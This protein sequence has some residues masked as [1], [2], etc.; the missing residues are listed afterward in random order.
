MDGWVASSGSYSAHSILL[1]FSRSF[2]CLVCGRSTLDGLKNAFVS[3]CSCRCQMDE[4]TSVSVRSSFA[5]RLRAFFPTAANS[6]AVVIPSSIVLVVRFQL[7]FVCWSQVVGSRQFVLAACG[8]FFFSFVF[9]VY[10]SLLALTLVIIQHMS[11]LRRRVGF[12]Y[13][14]LTFVSFSWSLLLAVRGLRGLCAVRAVSA[15]VRS[16]TPPKLFCFK[17]L[18]SCPFSFVGFCR[19]IADIRVDI[20]RCQR[21]RVL[22]SRRTDCSS[23]LTL[24]ILIRSPCKTV[25]IVCDVLS[26]LLTR[27]LSGWFSS[28]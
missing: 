28:G 3:F 26:L 24:S 13:S 1:L 27:R 19:R 12:V 17:H 5:S 18:L 16:R 20:A 25:S 4:Q 8:I 9:I 7:A 15:V 2:N 10:I 22:C 6:I 23:L 14:K 11:R 21:Q